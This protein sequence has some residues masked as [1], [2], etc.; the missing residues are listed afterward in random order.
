MCPAQRPH[1]YT[2]THANSTTSLTL[3]VTTG[4]EPATCYYK[5]PTLPIEL[6]QLS[7]T[8]SKSCVCCS[9]AAVED[10]GAKRLHVAGAAQERATEHLREA[11]GLVIRVEPDIGGAADEGEEY[12]LAVLMACRQCRHRAIALDEV[13]VGSMVRRVAVVE[14]PPISTSCQRTIRRWGRSRSRTF[15][16]VTEKRNQH[17]HLA[18][19]SSGALVGSRPDLSKALCRAQKV[20]PFKDEGDYSYTMT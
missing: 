16:A 4:L 12:P 15:G 3:E 9:P 2:H 1:F 11:P 17:K 6:R 14:R 7:P 20:R 13:R 19:S 18:S 10:E 5:S 8:R